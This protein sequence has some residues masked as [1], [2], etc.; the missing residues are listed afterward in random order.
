VIVSSGYSDDPV[1][2]QFKDYGFRACLTKPF[3]LAELRRV[4][5]SVLTE[6]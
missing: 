1:M 2:A 5:T 3:E 4:L 6:D